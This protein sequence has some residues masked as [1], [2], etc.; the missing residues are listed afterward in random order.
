MNNEDII[1]FL[2]NEY[3][4]LINNTNQPGYK[5]KLDIVN[6]YRNEW[7]TQHAK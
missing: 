6:A 4:T 7:E 1:K 2:M 5:V 3:Y